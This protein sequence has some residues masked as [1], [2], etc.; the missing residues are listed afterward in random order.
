MRLDVP[1]DLGIYL[2]VEPVDMRKSFD[3]LSALV[4]D[5]LSLNPL[6]GQLFVFRNKRGDK[7]KLLYWNHN[8]LVQWYKRLERG[9]FKWPTRSGCR[10]Q[11]TA[12]ELELLLDGVDISRIKRLPPLAFS[13]V[14]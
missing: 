14:I 3:G 6:S 1:R 7:I 11:V 2:A 13:G 12:Q 9:T 8:G 5:Q 4:A 10:F